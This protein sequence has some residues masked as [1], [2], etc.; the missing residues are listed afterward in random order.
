MHMMVRRILQMQCGITGLMAVL[1][2]L[3]GDVQNTITTLCAG[4]LVCLPNWIFARQCFKYQGALHA[5]EILHGFYFG[6]ACKVLLAALG[7]VYVFRYVDLNF[8][9]FFITY[10]VVQAVFWVASW[11]YGSEGNV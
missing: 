3:L 6:E 1:F 10:I 2:W 7:F 5:K 4:S 9:V 11:V 8:L